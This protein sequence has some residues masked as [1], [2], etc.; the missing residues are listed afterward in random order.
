[1]KKVRVQLYPDH[2]Y[3]SDMLCYVI[4]NDES[5]TEMIKRAKKEGKTVSSIAKLSLEYVNK[6]T[7]YLYIDE[8]M[9]ALEEGKDI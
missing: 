7:S 6:E 2:H 5:L 3:V 9:I 8:K 4:W 1:M